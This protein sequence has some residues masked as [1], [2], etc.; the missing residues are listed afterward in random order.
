[1]SMR[2][3]DRV[4]NLVALVAVAMLTVPLFLIFLGGTIPYSGPILSLFAVLSTGIGYGLQWGFASLTGKTSSRDGYDDPT[5]GVLGKF[6]IAYAA[7]PLFISLLLAVGV[8]FLYNMILMRMYEGAV[9]L[10]NGGFVHY[11]VLYPICAAILFFVAALSGCVIW[12]YP[13]ERLT[14]IYLVMGACTLFLIESIFLSVTARATAINSAHFIGINLGIPFI[15]F[16][17][18]VLVIYNQSNL[19][20]KYRGSVVS[21]ITGA[22]RRYNLF[23][24]LLL[25]VLFAVIFGIAYVMVVGFSYLMRLLLFVV[26]YH[27]FHNEAGGGTLGRNYEYFDSDEATGAVKS[28]S[29]ENQY[30]IGV[31]FLLLFS[32]AVLLL[33]WRT[34]VLK[35]IWLKIRDFIETVLIGIGIFRISFDPNE[36]DV[37]Y[38]Y[39]DEKKKIQKAQIGDY[40]SLAESTDS[41]GL[42]ISR[43]GKLKTYDEQLCFAYAVLRRMYKKM[44][45]ELKDSDTPREVEGKVRRALT[46]SEIRKIT[47]DFE[48]IRYAEREP[49]DAEASSILSNICTAVKRYMY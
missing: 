20:K 15:V 28:M 8:F 45:V 18:C 40:R 6:S 29:P 21:V 11:T 37:I 43:L 48:S 46:E 26:L 35:K 25:A 47:E 16:F 3:Y 13:V 44:N 1:M 39:K 10:E 27:L 36:K 23:L 49:D 14:G 38:N 24:V 17:L 33:A 31:F 32:I 30:I 19:Q 42:F 7:V 5:R 4:F 2:F 9:F 41:Y 34:G 12:F 22:E